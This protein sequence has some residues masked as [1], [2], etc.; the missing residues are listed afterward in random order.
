MEWSCHLS[1]SLLRRTSLRSFSH[2]KINLSENHCAHTFSCHQEMVTSRWRSFSVPK[3]R[4][5]GDP[6][7]LGP[8]APPSPAC[9]RL[10]GG[11]PA[12]TVRPGKV[13]RNLAKASPSFFSKVLTFCPKRY[14]QPSPHLLSVV[15]PYT[16]LTLILLFVTIQKQ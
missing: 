10:P 6:A 14:F 5:A 8:P 9:H 2:N 13:F 12:S 11:A 15:I 7:S 4:C 1:A 16:N 3:S